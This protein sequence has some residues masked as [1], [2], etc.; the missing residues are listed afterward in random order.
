M[1]LATT[2][3]RVEPPSLGDPAATPLSPPHIILP[4]AD[5][6]ITASAEELFQLIGKARDL[7]Y[8]GGRV[9]EI[10]KNPDGSSRLVPVTPSRFRSLIEI[11]GRLFTWRAGANGER[12][13]KPTVCP[14][15]TARALLESRPAE[16]R[17]PNVVTLTACPVLARR[18]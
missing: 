4:G 8:R 3:L 2:W 14:E 1:N 11:Y 7:F 5:H 18:G 17:L 15:E 9:H 12:V 13:L 16:T 6:S 10:A